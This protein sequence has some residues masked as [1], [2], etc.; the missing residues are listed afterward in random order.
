MSMLP[1]TR[2]RTDGGTQTRACIRPEVVEEYAD[3][4]GEMPPITVFYD[5]A[6]YWLADGFHRLEANK[7]QHKAEIDCDIR[8]GTLR[9]AV[10]YSFS[11]NGRHGLR[12]SPED[13]E[14]AVRKALNDVEWCNKSDRWISELVGCSHYL[15][16]KIRAQLVARPVE[17]QNSAKPPAANGA[18]P[19]KGAKTSAKRVGKDGKARKSSKKPKVP[20]PVYL[21]ARCSRVGSASCD[22][23]RAKNRPV[24]DPRVTHPPESAKPAPDIDRE[25]GIEENDE[26]FI[27]SSG[28]AI[29]GAIGEAFLAPFEDALSVCQQLQ[30]MIDKLARGPGGSQLARFLQPKKSSGDK[31]IHRSQHLDALKQDLKGTRPHSVCPYCQGKQKK[32]CKGCT[33]A[34]WVTKITWDGCDDTVKARLK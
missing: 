28:H 20:K 34:G 5:G 3:L 23:C 17:Q 1:I 30:A 21:C 11:A 29:P 9:Q 33:G 32:D 22:K 4:N 15:V 12:L 7:R 24:A 26:P 19:K 25:P 10:L 16:A 6:A 2:V 13:K 27:D 8:Q 14:Y 18:A 31:I